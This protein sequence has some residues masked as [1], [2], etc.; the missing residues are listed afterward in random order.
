M[1]NLIFSYCASPMGSV[2]SYQPGASIGLGLRPLQDQA[3]T[4]YKPRDRFA[5]CPDLLFH[6]F[7]YLDDPEDVIKCRVVCKKWY[8]GESAAR[9]GTGGTVAEHRKE[10]RQIQA[11]ARTNNFF[12]AADWKSHG[13]EVKRLRLPLELGCI[14]EGPC[15]FF[16]TKQVKDTHILFLLPE[17]VNGRPFTVNNFRR[18]AVIGSAVIQYRFFDV[19]LKDQFGDVPPDQSRWIL[20][21]KN[22]I[23]DSRKKSFADQQ[24]LVR[25][26]PGYE[27]PEILAAITGIFTHRM[28]SG[29]MIYPDSTGRTDGLM[30]YT[31]CQEIYS[32]EYSAIVGGLGGSGLA[33]LNSLDYCNILK[34]IGVGALRKFSGT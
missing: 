8:N 10:K 24:R 20:M 5:E 26:V 28:K 19:Q 2:F 12:G 30:T 23:L 16:P 13:F 3:V 32:N 6:I 7:R 17:K 4:A 21:T 9:A 14:L 29:E 25:A 11:F 31:R 33:V 27:V 22:V 15:P 18:N 34:D 1:I